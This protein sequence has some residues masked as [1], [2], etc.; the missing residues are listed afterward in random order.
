MTVAPGDKGLRRAQLIEPEAGLVRAE[1]EDDYHRFVVF[2]A[3]DGSRITEVRTESPRPPWTTCPAAGDHLRDRLVGVPLNEVATQDDPLSH[4]THMLD[5]AI[6]AAA[7][8]L[9][10]RP[11]AYTML[12]GDAVDGVK[13]AILQRDGGEI[14]RWH[15]NNSAL[16]EPGMMAGRDLRTLKH[17]IG[18]LDP[19]LHEPVRVLRRAVFIAQ[20]R[21]FNHAKVTTAAAAMNGRT[22]CYTFSAEHAENAWRYLDSIRDFDGL[23]TR[24]LADRLAP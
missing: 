3:H 21:G 8:A 24:P 13:T 22:A 23:K 16:L 14:L 5:L 11:T 9:D 18:E 20:G 10:Q 17:W 15:V 4:C 2:L 1:V 12:V 19:V 7:H 6:F